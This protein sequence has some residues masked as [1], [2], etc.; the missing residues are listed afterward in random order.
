MWAKYSTSGTQKAHL[1]H[2]MNNWLS[3]KGWKIINMLYV[4]FLCFIID[5]DIIEEDQQKIV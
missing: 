1:E 2:F 3:L 5:Q 4:W